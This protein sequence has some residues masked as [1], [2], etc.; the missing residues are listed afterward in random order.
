MNTLVNSIEDDF[1][2]NFGGAQ[3]VQLAL[4]PGKDERRSLPRDWF[5]RRPAVFLLKFSFAVSLIMLGFVAIATW[6]SWPIILAAILVNGLM[7]AHLIELQHECLHG[8]A[9]DWPGANRFFG[10]LCGLFMFSP[11]SH[12]RYDHLRHHVYLGTPKNLEHFSYRFQ[13]LDSPVGFARAFFDLERYKRVLRL[14]WLSILWEPLPGVDK[15]SYNRHIKQEYLLYLVIFVACLV[16]TLQTGSMLFVL[17]WW[18]PTLVVSEGVHFMIE[19]PE[20]FG[21]NTQTEPNVFTNTRTIN[22]SPI[23]A[24]FVNGNHVHTAHHFHQGVPM[25]NIDRVHGLINDRIEVRESSYPS[26]YW[27]VIT[28]AIRQDPSLSC[29]R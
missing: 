10:I 23:A 6:Q 21:L 25:R 16:Y 7:F 2:R 5:V 15:E 12:Y 28:G 9:F 22:A 19:M 18:I 26:F 14:T 3:D 20:H 27:R 4:V 1:E 24:W 8:H 17:A 11:H 29:M 13:D